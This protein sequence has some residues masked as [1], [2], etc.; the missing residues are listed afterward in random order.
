VYQNTKQKLRSS[1]SHLTMHTE[2]GNP[3]QVGMQ[4]LTH[5]HSQYLH[6]DTYAENIHEAD[7]HLPAFRAFGYFINFS[8]IEMRRHKNELG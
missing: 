3:E 7:P 1:L 5:L 4:L 8:R 2:H 6:Y